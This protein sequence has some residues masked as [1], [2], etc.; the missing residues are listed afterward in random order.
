[1]VYNSQNYWVF[2]F[3]PS[4]GILENTA[5]R[6]LF[7]FRPQVRGKEIPTLLGPLER[8]NPTEYVWPHSLEGENKSSFRNFVFSVS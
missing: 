6:D 1:M 4:V 3:C 5:F 7:C 2:A 8:A